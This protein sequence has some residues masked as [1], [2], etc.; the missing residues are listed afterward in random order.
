MAR[1]SCGHGEKAKGVGIKTVELP[2]MAEAR[3]D[4]LGA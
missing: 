3:D 1:F 4:G 2:L